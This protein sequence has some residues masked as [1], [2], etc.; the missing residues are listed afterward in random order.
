VR[1]SLAGRAE[2]GSTSTVMVD[3]LRRRG[4]G[5]SGEEAT[6]LLLGVYE[7]TG[8]LT[9]PTT[10]PRDLEAVAWLLRHGGD[11]GAVRRFAARQLDATH[12]DVLHR[13]MHGLEIHRLRGHRVG[14]VA[15]ELG[16]YVDELAP[17]VSR[18]LE[19]SSCRCC[20]RCSAKPGASR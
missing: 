3:E 19:L 20:S 4:V 7:D 9:Y 12:L 16:A 18:C 5:I 8:S 14:V 6:L 10:G 11:L 17:L 15:L 1:A 2:A 13:M